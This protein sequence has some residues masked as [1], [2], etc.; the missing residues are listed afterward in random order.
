MAGGEP[1]AG[2]GAGDPHPASSAAAQNAEMTVANDAAG[3]MTPSPWEYSVIGP[4]SV[5]PAGKLGPLDPWSLRLRASGGP[6]IAGRDASHVDI[7]PISIGRGS[8]LELK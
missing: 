2:A 4:F 3:R 7:P 6:S 8:L 5:L 1:V